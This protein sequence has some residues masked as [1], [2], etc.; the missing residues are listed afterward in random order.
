[1]KFYH[2]F[3]LL[4]F[5]LVF[6]QGL[7]LQGVQ[8]S[9][10]GHVTVNGTPFSGEGKFKFAL[11]D[12]G[13]TSILW[14]HE[15]NSSTTPTS[16]IS[17]AV[18]NGFYSVNL[19]DASM[20]PLPAD[21][22]YGNSKLKLRVWFNDGNGNGSFPLSPDQTLSAAP[23]AF[24]AEIAKNVPALESQLASLTMSLTDI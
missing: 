1:V 2:Y 12:A 5:P 13:G 20:A 8:L 15:N 24:S 11:V 18:E 16:E 22:F 3:S 9:H 17:I 6:L 21:L 4:C 19:G 7:P 14:S 10:H 23:Y